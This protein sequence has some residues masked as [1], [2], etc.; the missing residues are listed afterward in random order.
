MLPTFRV[1]LQTPKTLFTDFSF[2]S[3]VTRCGFAVSLKG[4]L[5]RTPVY[6]AL[7][8]SSPQTLD[9]G[10]LDIFGFEEFQKNEFEQV[11]WFSFLIL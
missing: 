5:P 3:A 4:R 2:K 7:F 8:P 11:S 10:I 6:S 1:F 9:I